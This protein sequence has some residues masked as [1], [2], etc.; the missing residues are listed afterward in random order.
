[1]FND[2]F[3]NWLIDHNENGQCQIL[4]EQTVIID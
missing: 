2:Q 4:K 3:I 1:M